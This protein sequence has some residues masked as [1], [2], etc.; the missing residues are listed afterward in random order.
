MANFSETDPRE[1]RR[2]RR[3][4]VVNEAER[5]LSIKQQIRLIQ[6]QRE[7]VI[8][9]RMAGNRPAD[10]LQTQ[11]HG[12]EDYQRASTADRENV[13]LDS[14]EIDEE[15]GQLRDGTRKKQIELGMTHE[16]DQ[17]ESGQYI[18]SLGT[19]SQ[20]SQMSR[21]T[22]MYEDE[23]SSPGRA[24][25]G[26]TRTP[27]K[28]K[29]EVMRQ[30]RV[31]QD[32]ISD[33]P[34]REVT[35]TRLYSGKPVMYSPKAG[36]ILLRGATERKTELEGRHESTQKRSEVGST[37]THKTKSG[38]VNLSVQ[39]TES[40][41]LGDADGISRAEILLTELKKL[42]G[43]KETEIL[44]TPNQ[45]LMRSSNVEERNAQTQNPFETIDRE[46]EKLNLRLKH[47]MTPADYKDSPELYK[48]D[49]RNT[50]TEKTTR[51]I[52]NSERL[53]ISSSRRVSDHNIPINEHRVTTERTGRDDNKYP[54]VIPDIKEVS[55]KGL[56][57]DHYKGGITHN[58][59]PS[60]EDHRQITGAMKPDKMAYISDQEDR[61]RAPD[62][63]RRLE[64]KDSPVVTEPQNV[65]RDS[66]G[67]LFRI[68]YIEEQRKIDPVKVERGNAIELHSQIDR[69][70]NKD[71]SLQK[72]YVVHEKEANMGMTYDNYGDRNRLIEDHERTIPSTNVGYK[73]K[74]H[75]HI[76]DESLFIDSDGVTG[77]KLVP[78]PVLIEATSNERKQDYLPTQYFGESNSRPTV[79]NIVRM[80]TE[81]QREYGRQEFNSEDYCTNRVDMSRVKTESRQRR[82]IYLQEKEQAI[83]MKEKELE[84]R[85]RMLQCSEQRAHDLEA[86]DIY[87]YLLQKKEE[88]L[89]LKCMLLESR[90]RQIKSRE[91]QI[92]IG[93]QNTLPIPSK[94]TLKP[95]I[96]CEP[97]DEPTYINTIRNKEINQL[98]VDTDK[99]KGETPMLKA[100]LVDTDK[101]A[102]S[103]KKQISMPQDT[104]A[105][106]SSVSQQ[107]K[108]SF[109]P[110]FTLFSGEEPRQKNEASFEE[111]QYEV[112]CTQNEGIY[113][114]HAIAQSIRRSLKGQAKKVLLPMGTTS[115][116]Q[117]ILD[118]LESVFGNVA[119][120]ESVM[121]E[122]YTATQKQDETVTAWGLRLEEIL[123]KAVSKGH[124]K[125]E[126][127]DSMLKAKFWR[128]L[129]SDRLKN[130]TRIHYETATSFEILRKKVR[131][132][133]YEMKVAS[134]VQ[135]QPTQVDSKGGKQIE[136]ESTMERLL[137]RLTSL[138]KQMKQMNKKGNR[139]WKKNERN[140]D[141]TEQEKEDE[142][143]MNPLN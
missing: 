136:K 66:D 1:I 13:E 59:I 96:K 140:N 11:T 70:S 88:E 81:G 109:C 133:E 47:S 19:K 20:F 52:A 138:E 79:G 67:R 6:Q 125:Q 28:A 50:R 15:Q 93:I 75:P 36:S 124:V 22:P 101:R 5:L 126:E 122:F 39:S 76:P 53:Q 34:Q 114:D 18:A 107:D 89:N 141:Q 110:K 129:R 16:R 118:R 99:H 57:F 63:R 100:E 44:K 102:L 55:S 104:K 84:N 27:D 106:D 54:T 132:E 48:Q 65:F 17:I 82:E 123:Q 24:S 74:T 78:K 108:Q 3:E 142:E 21:N 112:K 116:V 85:E 64:F 8:Q 33:L 10:E 111:W 73:R 87:E 41:G 120:G 42:I 9:S 143:E 43:G 130:A 80:E 92:K 38:R 30:Q 94:V 29:Y 25:M 95:Q 71:S 97:A 121:Q 46:I 62:V 98:K 72:G 45:P 128:C 134:G 86:D 56:S 35:H 105:P 12:V 77:Y 32:D 103:E 137:I 31:S 139:Y 2:L 113:P 4:E 49:S 26:N 14:G 69:S 127:I 37:D 68:H 61:H 83:K 135:H 51:N 40:A 90:E 23:S 117:D 115:S 7:A 58:L 131:A 119:A 91:G 60:N